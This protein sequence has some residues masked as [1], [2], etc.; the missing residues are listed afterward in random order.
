MTNVNSVLRDFWLC[1]QKSQDFIWTIFFPIH[2]S[3]LCSQSICFS[4]PHQFID[5]L[6]GFAFARARQKLLLFIIFKKI[7][8]FSFEGTGEHHTCE[9]GDQRII[10]RSCFLA[11]SAE[12]AGIKLRQIDLA[13]SMFWSHITSLIISTFIVECIRSQS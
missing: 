7:T 5:D 11:S 2:H 1:F 10:S 6:V 9:C 4:I 12:I 8:L 13:L 3:V